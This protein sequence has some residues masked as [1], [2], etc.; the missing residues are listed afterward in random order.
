[1]AE[2]DY[3][4]SALPK[5]AKAHLCMNQLHIHVPE[6]GYTAGK[7]LVSKSFHHGGSVRV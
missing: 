1:M 5:H 2:S 6:P 4:G 7:A 3:D